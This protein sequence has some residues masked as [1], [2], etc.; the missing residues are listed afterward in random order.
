MIEATNILP[1][2]SSGDIKGSVEPPEVLEALTEYWGKPSDLIN[3]MAQRKVAN[4]CLVAIQLTSTPQSWHKFRVMRCA[5]YA[6]LNGVVTTEVYNN[7]GFCGT[8]QN[9]RL[10]IGF[11]HVCAIHLHNVN[12]VT[13]AHF[14]KVHHDE[15][16]A[17]IWY[18]ANGDMLLLSMVMSI[19]TEKP[20]GVITEGRPYGLNTEGVLNAECRY[21]GPNDEEWIFERFETKLD[22]LTSVQIL[23]ES[24]R[25]RK[26]IGY[27]ANCKICKMGNYHDVCTQCYSIIT[28]FSRKEYVIPQWAVRSCDEGSKFALLGNDICG[29]IIGFIAAR[30]N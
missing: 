2:W 7:C 24:R 9:C 26:Y 23:R 19:I 21:A 20:Y 6:R 30:V 25:S 17:D 11:G 3:I 4:G 22:S 27:S 10:V 18:A 28:E 12:N 1:S 8:I 29:V 13:L 15:S 16:I 14:G 5:M